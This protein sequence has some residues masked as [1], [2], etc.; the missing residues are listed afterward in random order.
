[1]SSRRGENAAGGRGHAVL[2]ALAR[3]IIGAAAIWGLLSIIG[4]ILTHVFDKGPVHRVDLGVD[5]WFEHHRTKTWTSIMRFATDMGKTETVIIVTAV[6]MVLLWLL[7]RRWRESLI[8][9]TSVLG[10]VLIFLATTATVPQRRP[11]VHRLGVAPPTS[12][13]PS[14]HTGASVALYGCIAI[15]LLANYAKHPAARVAAGLLFCVPV[16]V[17]ISRLYEGE[18]YPSDVLAGALLASLWL[19]VV[20]HTI[21]I[22]SP[23]AVAER[24]A[25]AVAGT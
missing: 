19:T 5:V 20:L 10:E 6:V 4:L 14:G 13:F 12:S 17:A 2:A 11:P 1:M 21:R 8:L 7:T 9:L 25:V 3:L 15:L 24:D 16:F 23:Q 22:R 18:H